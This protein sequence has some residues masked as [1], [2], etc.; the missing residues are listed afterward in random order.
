MAG[1]FPGA[2][3]LP[4][5]LVPGWFE[6]TPDAPAEPLTEIGWWAVLTLDLAEVADPAQ[7]AVLLAIKRVALASLAASTQSVALQKIAMSVFT[8]TATSAQVLALRKIALEQLA[9]FVG[10]AGGVGG[11]G[12]MLVRI[13][14]V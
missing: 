1:W 13:R 8:N 9:N 11:A 12:Q 14:Q 7:A 4:P 10:Q 5:V 3:S 6:D 2:P